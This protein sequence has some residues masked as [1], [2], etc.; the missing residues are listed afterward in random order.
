M[1]AQEKLRAVA[2]GMGATFVFDNWTAV[3][4]ALDNVSLP[5]VVYILPADGEFAIKNGRVK[6]TENGMLAFLD[7][8]ESFE[9]GDTTVLDAMKVLALR[10]LSRLNDIGEFESIE[11]V[12]KYKAVYDMLDVG[13]AGVMINVSL[14]EKLGKCSKGY[15]R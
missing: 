14:K 11:G 9:D 1:T 10:F 2:Q 15:E 4:N 13:V 3:N 7:K 5:A 12:I 6:D 8:V